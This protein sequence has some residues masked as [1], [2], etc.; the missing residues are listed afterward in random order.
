ME[1]NSLGP[2]PFVLIQDNFAPFLD[3]PHQDMLVPL[4]WLNLPVQS[5]FGEPVPC[6]PV[7]VSP[8]FQDPLHPLML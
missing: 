7:P 3:I 2:P 6:E 8:I 4:T 1:T 5:D